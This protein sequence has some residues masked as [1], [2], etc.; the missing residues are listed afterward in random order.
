[1]HP[2]TGSVPVAGPIAPDAL[3]T[4]RRRIDPVSIGIESLSNAL[5]GHS[6]VPPA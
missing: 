5:G 1:L 2:A 6:E 4:K 3:G